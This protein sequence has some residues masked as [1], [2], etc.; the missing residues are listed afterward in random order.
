MERQ[1]ETGG[2]QG[3]NELM[4]WDEVTKGEDGVWNGNE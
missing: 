1:G 3:K 4:R 2:E